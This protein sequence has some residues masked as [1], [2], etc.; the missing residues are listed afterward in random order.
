MKTIPKEKFLVRADLNGQNP[1]WGYSHSNPR[2]EAILNFVLA[3]NLYINNTPDAPPTFTRNTDKGW[4]DLTVCSQP[5]IEEIENWEVL[6]EPSFSD[7]HFIQTNFKTTITSHT[8][9]G[10]NALH[11]NH[12]KFK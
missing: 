11:R 1:L 10:Y 2:G 3:N 4:T 12:H 7:H 6:E 8:F 5:R 9:K